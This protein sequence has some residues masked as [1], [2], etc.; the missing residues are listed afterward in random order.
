MGFNTP[1]DSAQFQIPEP[2]CSG[3]PFH[4]FVT[5]ILTPDV[6]QTR[7]TVRRFLLVLLGT[8]FYSTRGRRRSRHTRQACWVRNGWGR[9][10]RSFL[11]AFAR[12]AVALPCRPLAPDSEHVL[13]CEPLT[14]PSRSQ[15]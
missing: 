10:R 11:A 1:D 12:P 8:L 2:L 13:P 6:I 14:A 4:R 3:S 5:L 15:V 9:R 7:G